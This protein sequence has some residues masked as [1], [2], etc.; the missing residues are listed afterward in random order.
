MLKEIVVL[1]KGTKTLRWFYDTFTAETAKWLKAA[2]LTWSMLLNPNLLFIASVRGKTW[3]VN[4]GCFECS[5]RVH[6]SIRGANI[7]D[8]GRFCEINLLLCERGHSV[9]IHH[10]N[11][12]C[13]GTL[14]KTPCCL[15][16]LGKLDKPTLNIF[17]RRPNNSVLICFT[18]ARL[19]FVPPSQREWCTCVVTSSNT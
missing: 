11:L 7:F 8:S 4:E 19:C 6:I 1:T 17:H 15:T 16:T 10:I 2:G 18:R 14:L 13:L 5:R 9:H 12:R 3:L